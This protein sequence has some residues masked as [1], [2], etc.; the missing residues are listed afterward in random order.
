VDIS[1][2]IMI[3]EVSSI[4]TYFPRSLLKIKIKWQFTP[5]LR[6]FQFSEAALEYDFI[7]KNGH[8]SCFLTCHHQ[9]MNSSMSQKCSPQQ[10]KSETV[11]SFKKLGLH[12]WEK[13][14][15]YAC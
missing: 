9:I 8:F 4:Q 1:P 5:E 14:Q 3:A 15:T 12:Y 7:Y 13:L 6:V 10:K 11:F 2:K